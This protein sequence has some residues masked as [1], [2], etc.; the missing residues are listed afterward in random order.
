MQTLSPRVHDMLLGGRLFLRGQG[1]RSLT[2]NCPSKI[3]RN[4]FQST[5]RRCLAELQGK[6]VIYSKQ[7]CP[8]CDGLKDKI[9]GIIDRAPFTNSMLKAFKLEIRDIGTDPEWQERFA[10]QV[11]VL[12]IDLDGEQEVSKS[13]RCRFLTPYATMCDTI[14]LFAM[15]CR[16]LFRGL[17]PA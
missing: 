14:N 4:Q 6:I 13:V 5:S 16:L 8:L 3:Q 10:M 2:H 7:E 17:H 9:G 12:A 11:P 15:M 1:F